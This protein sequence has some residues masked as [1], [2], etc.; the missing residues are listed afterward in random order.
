[1]AVKTYQDDCSMTVRTTQ[2][3]E[4]VALS[5]LK[6]LGWFALVP[7]VFFALLLVIGLLSEWLAATEFFQVTIGKR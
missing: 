4:H 1:M 2:K 3:D 7:A 6:N 5:T